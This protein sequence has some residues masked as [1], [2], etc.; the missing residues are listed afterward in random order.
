MSDDTWNRYIEALEE[1]RRLK[2][3]RQAR[4]PRPEGDR[5]NAPNGRYANALTPRAPDTPAHVR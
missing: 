5:G 3:E 1:L 2:S 4:I